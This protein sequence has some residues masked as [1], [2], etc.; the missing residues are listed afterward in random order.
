MAD[1]SLKITVTTSE[2]F[3]HDYCDYDCEHI[4]T[5]TKFPPVAICKITGAT[6]EA[7]RHERFERPH[8]CKYMCGEEVP[9]RFW[10]PLRGT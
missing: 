8:A 9:N 4:E 10:S 6:L 7:D 2:K 3:G 5:Y 1:I